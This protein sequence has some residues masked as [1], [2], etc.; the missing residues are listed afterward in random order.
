MKKGRPIKSGTVINNVIHFVQKSMYIYESKNDT[1]MSEDYDDP[2]DSDNN[3][4][5]M[6]NL[7]K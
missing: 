5:I 4:K 6:M 1:K 7:D 3:T 2:D